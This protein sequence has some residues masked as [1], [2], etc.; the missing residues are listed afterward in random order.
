MLFVKSIWIAFFILL[1]VIYGIS[2][3]ILGQ[4]RSTDAGPIP[5][6]RTRPAVAAQPQPMPRTKSAY[7]VNEAAYDTAGYSEISGTGGNPTMQRN[8]SET[9][10]AARAST[11][12][13]AST[14]PT[15]PARQFESKG[16]QDRSE[17]TREVPPAPVPAPRPPVA[18]TDF[19]PFGNVS[20]PA[21]EE[22]ASVQLTSRGAP[23]PIPSVRPNGEL[24]PPT[25]PVDAWQPVNDNDVGVIPPRPK[26]APVAVKQDMP[27][28]PADN[29]PPI[30][31][32]AAVAPPPIPSRSGVPPGN[33]PQIP[34][35][36]GTNT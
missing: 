28:R 1:D 26:A 36:Q 24:P 16:S 33:I 6:Q 32:R 19:N 2:Y 31:A 9:N 10:L 35:R 4:G 17:L 11:V 21:R 3:P 22:A 5:A 13:T 8:F 34:P 27:A 20:P 23:P 7:E 18:T 12:N 15:I 25:R 30:P 14:T 29:I